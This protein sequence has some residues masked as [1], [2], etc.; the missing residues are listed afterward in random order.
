MLLGVGDMGPAVVKIVAIAEFETDE[1]GPVG[2]LAESPAGPDCDRAGVDPE[3]AEGGRPAAVMITVV[4]RRPAGSSAGVA[5][6]LV[7]RGAGFTGHL[8]WEREPDVRRVPPLIAGKPEC[9]LMKVIE[10]AMPDR[11]NHLRRRRVAVGTFSGSVASSGFTI[12]HSS[13]FSIRI[14]MR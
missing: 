3:E 9:R 1:A 14:A 6:D 12:N 13:N 2:E 4:V 11:T 7:F 5:D 10:V 8:A